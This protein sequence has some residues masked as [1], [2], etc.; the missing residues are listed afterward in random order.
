[1]DKIRIGNDIKIRWAIYA[2]SGI[3]EA[4]YN[5]EGRN[6]SLY[7]KNFKES[8]KVSTFST[9]GHILDFT[10]YGKDQDVTG[11]Y[12][13]ELIENEGL[14]DMHS[15]DECK[16]FAL[17]NHSCQ[18][19][20][21][22][23]GRVECVH[24]QFKATIGVGYPAASSIIVDSVLSETSENPVQNKVVTSAIVNMQKAVNTLNGTIAELEKGYTWTDV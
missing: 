20:N 9:S 22:S 23:E 7:L 2:G 17:V 11:T 6:L 4:P 15:V 24:L 13:V 1:M 21:D 16:A 14:V 12:S 8:K 19:D 5:L 18:A 3:N 10:F